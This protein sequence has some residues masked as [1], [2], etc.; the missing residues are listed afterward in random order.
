MLDV[1]TAYNQ[2][3]TPMLNDIS[4]WTLGEIS[5]DQAAHPLDR[6]SSR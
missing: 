6:T 3:L 5:K 2:A 1:V 4:L